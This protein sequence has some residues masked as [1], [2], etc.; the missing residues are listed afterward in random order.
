MNSSS[1]ATAVAPTAAG[2]SSFGPSAATSCHVATRASAT[3]SPLRFAWFPKP[4]PGRPFLP[5]ARSIRNKLP[6]DSTSGSTTNPES[7]RNCC[8]PLPPFALPPPA[9]GS[10][11]GATAS[12]DISPEMLASTDRSDALWRP[13]TPLPTPPAP[14][15]TELAPPKSASSIE[16]PSVS[17]LGRSNIGCIAGPANAASLVPAANAGFDSNA[18]ARLA[19]ESRP[20]LR[21]ESP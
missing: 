8:C 9:L 12:L 21:P 5:S 18:E 10:P 1:A 19:A 17:E 13:P 2:V 4:P 7:V 14:P 11:P 20:G 16:P 3:L 6:S 15:E